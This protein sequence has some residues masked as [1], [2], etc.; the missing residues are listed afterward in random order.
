MVSIEQINEIVSKNCELDIRN[1]N[2][3]DN[4]ALYRGMA[5]ELASTYSFEEIPNIA[6]YYSLDRTSAIGWRDNLQD[7]VK[8]DPKNLNI[9]LKSAKEVKTLAEEQKGNPEFRRPVLR[10][11]DLKPESEKTIERRLRSELKKKGGWALKMLATHVS[12]LPDRVCL[13]P[14]GVVFFAEIKTTDKKTTRIQKVIHRKLRKMGFEVF[15]IDQ[16]HQIKDI[17]DSYGKQV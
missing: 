2:R 10:R 9:Y 14:G 8:N 13:L 16:T 6:E 7:K 17:L 4:R 11:K 3:K 12:G 15:I 5:I 1:N